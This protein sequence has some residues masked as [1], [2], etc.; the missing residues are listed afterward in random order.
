MTNSR[1]NNTIEVT[2]NQIIIKENN[3]LRN[4]NISNTNIQTYQI[5]N[6]NICIYN[7]EGNANLSQCD[8]I[9]LLKYD[10]LYDLKLSSKTHAIIYQNSLKLSNKLL[11]DIYLNW[12]DTY[13]NDNIYLLLEESYQIKNIPKKL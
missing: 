3:S 10:D 11:E 2:K 13:P 7:I 8:F 6:Y 5:N 12:I 1:E 4:D 9:Y